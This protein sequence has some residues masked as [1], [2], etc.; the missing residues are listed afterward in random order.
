M[1]RVNAEYMHRRI[2][3]HRWLK[4]FEQLYWSPMKS[5]LAQQ[6]LRYICS[7][8]VHNNVVDCRKNSTSVCILDVIYVEQSLL[9]R[10]V[11]TH[12]VVEGVR[13]I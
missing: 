4:Y 8:Q 7:L 11:I 12:S 5:A 9:G 2:P 6:Y 1:V 13:C 10:D 3:S